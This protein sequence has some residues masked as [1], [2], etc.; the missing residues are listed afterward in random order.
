MTPRIG[1]LVTGMLL[2]VVLYWMPAKLVWPWIRSIRTRTQRRI[3]DATAEAI[4]PPPPVAEAIR[5]L[6]DAGLVRIGESKTHLPAGEAVAWHLRN[7]DGTVT[8]D[9]LAYRERCAVGFSTMFED[10]SVVETS[11]PIGERFKTPV[12]VS[13]FTHEGIQAA[14]DLHARNV[15]TFASRRQSPA[16]TATSMQDILLGQRLYRERHFR[17]HVSRPLR[18]S[19]LMTFFLV[20]TLV[21]T[22]VALWQTNAALQTSPENLEPVVRQQ[23]P[24]ILVGGV[25]LAGFLLTL[26]SFLYHAGQ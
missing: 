14:L 13:D 24:L 26:R 22:L 5:Q 11:Y 15:K 4:Q 1:M 9:L 18:R 20:L 3:D 8:A 17:R 16:R 12:H 21:V 7:P 10:E 19:V 6:G 2:L 23:W 25:S